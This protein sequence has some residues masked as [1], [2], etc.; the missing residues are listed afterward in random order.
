VNFFFAWLTSCFDRR[1][2]LVPLARRERLKIFVGGLGLTAQT[3][4]GGTVPMAQ[5]ALV[6]ESEAFRFSLV[7]HVI[8][9][10]PLSLMAARGFLTHRAPP[11]L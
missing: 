6:R 3:S 1:L 11:V 4:N 8:S 5:L 2:A 10:I 7:T 9:F